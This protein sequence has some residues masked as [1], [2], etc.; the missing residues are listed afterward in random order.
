MQNGALWNTQGVDCLLGGLIAQSSAPPGYPKTEL[1]SIS[2]WWCLLCEIW[3]LWE[4]HEFCKLSHELL[5]EQDRSRTGQECVRLLAHVVIFY[6]C[7]QGSACCA[8]WFYC[9]LSC[10]WQEELVFPP[11]HCRMTPSMAACHHW[12]FLYGWKYWT[13]RPQAHD[14]LVQ[15]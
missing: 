1:C 2:K 4:L 7:S 14:S 11:P 10:D 15:L 6:W 5:E 13:E 12:G 3:S 8:W 9:S